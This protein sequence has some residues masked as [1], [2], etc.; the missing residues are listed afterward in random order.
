[1]GGGEDDKEAL[2]SPAESALQC[3]I[4]HGLARFLCLRPD[5]DRAGV[6]SAVA[7]SARPATSGN[8]IKSRLSSSGSLHTSRLINRGAPR[9]PWERERKEGGR[10]ALVGG[11]RLAAAA[12]G[13]AEGTAN[14]RGHFELATTPLK[15]PRPVTCSRKKGSGMGAGGRGF[16]AVNQRHRCL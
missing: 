5:P 9:I 7:L 13:E 6:H 2:C 4:T 15:N 12:L 1:M 8:I 10:G 14:R 16:G 3:V 11:A